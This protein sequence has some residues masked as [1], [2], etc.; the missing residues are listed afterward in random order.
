MHQPT[1]SEARR[2]AEDTTGV[3]ALGAS[4][5]LGGYCHYVYE[6]TLVNGGQVVARLAS[7]ETR[8]QMLGGIHWHAQLVPLGIPLPGML[9]AN[10][11]SIMP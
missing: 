8:Q 6:V 11:L 3:A 1:A 7:R 5:M 2:I 10:F 4:R 9:R